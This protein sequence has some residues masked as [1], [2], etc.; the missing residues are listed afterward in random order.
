MSTRVDANNIQ[1]WELES[2]LASVA[3]QAAIEL[4]NLL[5]GRKSVNLEAVTR[6]EALLG[7]SVTK[8]EEPQ[9]ASSGLNPATA[10]VLHLAINDS[11]FEHVSKLH[12]LLTRAKEITG[13]FNQLTSDP[14]DFSRQHRQI[15]EQMR[16]FCVALS[17]RAGAAS[18]FTFE[19]RP[20]HPFRR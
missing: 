18:H 6:L 2:D 8:V 1:A 14:N 11:A 13:L 16:N 4:D 17:K 15:I 3:N 20:S 10:V 19:E 9:A 7:E 5:I 12:E